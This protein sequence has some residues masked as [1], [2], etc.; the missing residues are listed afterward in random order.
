[1]G[2]IADV[3]PGHPM[4]AW[5]EAQRKAAAEPIVPVFYPHTE[6]TKYAVGL[7][8]GQAQDFTAITVL[9]FQKGVL[10]HGTALER[11][12]GTSKQTDAKRIDVR[13]L[14]RIKLNTSYPD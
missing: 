10:D 5:L 6:T 3:A 9:Q 8:L 1:M 2:L 14:E 7:D 11:H 12:T 4:S 13:H